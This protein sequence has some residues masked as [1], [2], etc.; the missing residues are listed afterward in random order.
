[1]KEYEGNFSM[2]DVI[3][4]MNTS[5][6]EE[7][8]LFIED[9]AHMFSNAGGFG[10]LTIEVEM[11]DKFFKFLNG[12]PSFVEFL[13]DRLFIREKNKEKSY[14]IEYITMN[15]VTLRLEVKSYKMIK[16]NN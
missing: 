12:N 1:M 16:V 14:T 7:Y 10:W 3:K 6:A 11:N 5:E 9:Y 8:N 15:D 13:I 2:F 4:S